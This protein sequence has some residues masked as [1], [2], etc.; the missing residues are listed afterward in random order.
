MGDGGL[1]D[2]VMTKGNFK[3]LPDS[4]LSDDF[5]IKKICFVIVLLL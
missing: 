4:M 2:H 3:S 1:N 5:P